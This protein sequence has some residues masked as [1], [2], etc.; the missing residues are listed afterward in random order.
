MQVWH[1]SDGLAQSIPDA[2]GRFRSDKVYVVLVPP[3]NGEGQQRLYLWAGNDAPQ[4]AKSTAAKHASELKETLGAAYLR[5]SQGQ[6]SDEFKQLFAGFTVVEAAPGG[7]E[8]VEEGD[9]LE[10]GEDEA[11][12]S[13]PTATGGKK[14]KRRAKK[15]SQQ[16]G[17]EPAEVG[18]AVVGS[19]KGAAAVAAPAASSPRQPNSP[20]AARPSTPPPATASPLTSPRAGVASPRT[21]Q[22]HVDAP[23]FTPRSMRAR[24]ASASPFGVP[25]PPSPAAPKSASPTAAQASPKPARPTA[26][27]A[28]PKPASPTAAQA[29]PT[30]AAAAATPPKPASPKVPTCCPPAALVLP[31][32]F[33]PAVDVPPSAACTEPARM[34][35]C[36]AALLHERPCM[37]TCWPRPHC[38]PTTCRTAPCQL[39]LA[40]LLHWAAPQLPLSVLQQQR[41]PEQPS[42]SAGSLNT[43]TPCSMTLLVFQLM[44]ISHITCH[45]S[46]PP[47]NIFCSPSLHMLRP[48]P[49]LQVSVEE[50]GPESVAK[51]KEQIVGKLSGSLVDPLG[52]K[53]QQRANGAAGGKS[54][55]TFMAASAKA[56]GG[57]SGGEAAPPVQA[58]EV[59]VKPGEKTFGYDELKALRAESGIDMTRKEAYLSDA[60][61]E[62]VFG[63]DRAAFQALPAWRQQMAKKD[64]GLW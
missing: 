46:H 9:E 1:F 53:Q 5:Q 42:R 48:V 44:R 62:K 10:E 15:K 58:V 56:W 41:Q 45:A 40:A 3:T 30:A 37:P 63:K 21:S 24:A 29:S 36:A 26:A 31:S 12:V 8:E 52:E 57:V 11:G 6:E 49:S 35:L 51:A 34:T 47:G 17:P 25:E 55:T 23:P 20:P 18:V 64:K 60:E 27:Q 50:S 33:S 54:G 7:G 43:C 61:F 4:D 39:L 28:S 32:C 19:P 13:S 14:K 59:K 22:L 38:P 2:D 16:G